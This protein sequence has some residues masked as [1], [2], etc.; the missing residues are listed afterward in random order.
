[1]NPPRAAADSFRRDFIRGQGM[2]VCYVANYSTRKNQA[3]AIRVFRKAGLKDATL[4]LIGSEFNAYS[5]QLKEI[6]LELRK[7]YPEGTVVMLEKLDRATTLAAYTACDVFLLAA[8]A[9][10]QPIV[11]LEAMAA[12][13]PFVTTDV[14][15]VTEL[16]GGIV[17]R[18]EAELSAALVT[19]QNAPDTRRRLGDEGKAAVMRDFSKEKVMAAHEA[20]IA[21]LCRDAQP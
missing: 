19:L 17:G 3:R 13:Q 15:C 20:L 1:M 6:D 10:T 2:S 16:P 12:G 8:D 11:L 14:G 4:I 21:E 9:E 18:N 7:R 5:A